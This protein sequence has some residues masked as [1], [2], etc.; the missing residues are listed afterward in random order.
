M[1]QECLRFVS[2]ERR[3]NEQGYSNTGKLR[4]AAEKEG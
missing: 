2:R 4:A 1:Q 3:E